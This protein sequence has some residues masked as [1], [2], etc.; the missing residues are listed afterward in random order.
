VVRLLWVVSQQVHPEI[1]HAAHGTVHHKLH[2]EGCG[3]AGLEDHRTDG[4]CGRSAP[5]DDFDVWRF[6][7]PEGL[8]A[9]IGQ[10][11]RCLDSLTK[12]Y[13]TKVYLLPVGF[14]AGGT[15]YLDGS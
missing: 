2:R 6:I 3:L 4:R 10:A 13:I 11:E 15:L 1:V 5:L 9:H 14:Q 7:E 8:V 12:F